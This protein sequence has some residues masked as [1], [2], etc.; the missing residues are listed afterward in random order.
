MNVKALDKAIQEIVK[1]REE[2]EKLDY[3]D[4][5]YDDLEEEL[6]D[7]EDDLQDEHGEY[8]E[9]A[10]QDVHDRLC[11]E[12][13]VLMPIAYIGKGVPVEVEKYD[14]KD[15]KLVLTYGPTRVVLLIGKD[16]EEIVWTAK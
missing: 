11:P 14:G 12:N 13:D 5:K 15:T 2:L 8:L 6:H 10:L 4:P 9:E 3:N 16:K 7:M 1:K